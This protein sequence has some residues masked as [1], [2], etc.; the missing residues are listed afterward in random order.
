[1]TPQPPD[2]D[3]ILI[4]GL[5]TVTVQHISRRVTQRIVERGFTSYRITHQAVFQWCAPEGSRLTTL[6]AQAGLSKQA[7][8]ELVDYLEQEGYVERIPD[9]TDARAI[10]VRRTERGWAVNRIAREVVEEVQQ[11]WAQ[12]L[13]E[14]NFQMLLAQLRQL[15]V[16]LNEPVGVA[17]DVRVRSKVS[18]NASPSGR[19]HTQASKK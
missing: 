12:V 14:E 17:N 16:H 2:Y 3:S 10:L 8:G 7:M 5:L 18:K 11:E 19:K 15:A 4:G 9:P 6:A 13:G 1:M